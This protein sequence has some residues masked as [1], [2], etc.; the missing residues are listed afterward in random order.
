[1][2]FIDGELPV[3]ELTRRNLT[4]LLAKLDDPISARM[5]IDPD[6]IIAVRAVE[7]SEHYSDR[8]PGIMLVK[9]ELI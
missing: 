5:I 1:M 2:K 6:N 7:D 4:T 3:L 9:G 8:P